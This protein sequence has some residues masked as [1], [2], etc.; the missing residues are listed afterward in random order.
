MSYVLQAFMQA[1]NVRLILR[2]HE[3]PDARFKRDDLDSMDN[4]YTID[5]VTPSEYAFST[6]AVRIAQW[7]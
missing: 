2:S 4:G 6:G 1:N 7:L 3:G 5:H